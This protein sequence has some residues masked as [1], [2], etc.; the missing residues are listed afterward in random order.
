MFVVEFLFDG[1]DVFD[2]SDCEVCDDCLCVLVDMF[3]GV[4]LLEL[5]WVYV[6]V[7]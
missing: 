1:C 5:V 4:D 2:L 3:C 7:V 6:V